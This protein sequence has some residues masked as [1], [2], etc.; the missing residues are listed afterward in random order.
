MSTP[1]KENRTAA[2]PEFSLRPERAEDEA[3]LFAVFASTREEELALTNWDAATRSA[4]LNQQ[5]AAMRRGYRGMFPA[6]EFLIIEQAGQPI[7]LMVLNRNETEIRVVDLALLPA[8]RNKKIGTFLM[9]G[10]CTGAK[11][12]VRLHV[13]KHNRAWHWYERLGFVRIGDAGIH[14]EM[15]WRPTLT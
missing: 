4:F 7:G 9:R 12:P 2:T 13:L 6:G 10:I 14:D 11:V 8:A 3:F 5:F 1:T 15:E